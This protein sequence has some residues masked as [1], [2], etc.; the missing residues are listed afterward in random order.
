M[1]SRFWWASFS[2]RT[3]SCISTGPRGPAVMLFWLSETGMPLS[4]VRVGRLA[5]KSFLFTSNRDP[6]NT[7]PCGGS[8]F[9]NV[10][11]P[12]STIDR[13]AFARSPGRG[14]K[15]MRSLRN[16]F[17]S[18][19]VIVAALLGS[20]EAGSYSAA[21]AQVTVWTPPD[22]RPACRRPRTGRLAGGELDARQRDEQGQDDQGGSEEHTAGC[23]SFPTQ[24]RRN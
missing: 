9:R 17:G 1:R 3:K 20:R 19:A 23:S 14:Q 5:M 7:T 12:T 24:R 11:V 18:I 4:V 22:R 6:G 21:A 13:L 15:C 2:N 16:D 10:S 8:L